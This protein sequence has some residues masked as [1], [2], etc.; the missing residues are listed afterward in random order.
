MAL[1]LEIWHFWC[2]KFSRYF[3]DLGTLVSPLSRRVWPLLSSFYL[4]LRIS[5]SLLPFTLSHLARVQ[6]SPWPRSCKQDKT[7]QIPPRDFWGPLPCISVL[8][9]VCPPIS[10][11]FTSAKL[12][13]CLLRAA[14]MLCWCFSSLCCSR[15]I[16]HRLTVR[17]P[18]GVLRDSISVLPVGQCLKQ[19]LPMFCPAL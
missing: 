7:K 15:E 8:S 6:C 9:S 2:P 10:R 18:L 3:Y 11:C 5:W 4:Q 19:S 14:R 17:A 12:N 1:I 13:A 16:V